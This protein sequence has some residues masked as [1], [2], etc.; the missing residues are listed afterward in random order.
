[1][2]PLNILTS[3]DPTLPEISKGS[4]CRNEIISSGREDQVIDTISYIHYHVMFLAV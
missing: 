4:G 3:Y 2:L 1:M